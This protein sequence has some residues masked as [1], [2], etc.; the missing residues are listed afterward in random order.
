MRIIDDCELFT[1]RMEV[2]QLAKNAGFCAIMHWVLCPV[3][4]ELDVYWPQQAISVNCKFHLLKVEIEN[5]NL[6]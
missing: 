1:T 4:V 5:S 2:R 6:F 3:T